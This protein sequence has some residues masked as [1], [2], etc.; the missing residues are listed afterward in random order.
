ME[1]ADIRALR[2]IGRM[3]V[4]PDTTLGAVRLNAGDQQSLAAFYERTVGLQPV[5]SENG[6]AALGTDDGRP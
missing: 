5:K 6:V 2:I 4:P 3:V 1:R